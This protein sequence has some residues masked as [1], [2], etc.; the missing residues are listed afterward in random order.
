[1]ESPIQG[2]P[3]QAMLLGALRSRGRG[4]AW[5]ETRETDNRFLPRAVPGPARITS[6]K[7]RSSKEGI[8]VE[9]IAAVGG[10]ALALAS[11]VLG[12]RPAGKWGICP[13]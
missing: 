12:A 9:L 3:P 2:A 10:G 5:F 11:L 8:T 13:P 7:C 6:G 4:L 1:M